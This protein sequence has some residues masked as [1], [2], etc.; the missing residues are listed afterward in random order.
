MGYENLLQS[1]QEIVRDYVGYKLWQ[2][3]IFL[4]GYHVDSIPSPEARLLRQVA[5]EL[6]EEN[7]Q[8]FLGFLAQV[9]ENIV[10][11]ISG[12]WV[13]DCGAVVSMLE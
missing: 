5:D 1:F 3:N 6:I 7:K 10:E 9:V 8:L 2:R 13:N 4:A 11:L 12:I